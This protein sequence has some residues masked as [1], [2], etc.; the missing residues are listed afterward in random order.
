MWGTDWTRAT[1]L[2][3]YAEAVAAFRDGDWL[4]PGE[5]AALIGETLERVFRWRPA[6]P[7]AVGDG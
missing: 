6:A 7:S 3:S 2:V 5:R 1:A 4:S